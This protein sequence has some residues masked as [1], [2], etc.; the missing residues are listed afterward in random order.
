MIDNKTRLPTDTLSK[1]LSFGGLV[2]F[3]TYMSNFY[4]EYLQSDTW[5][6]RRQAKL[7]Q[8]KYKC[9]RCGERTRLQ[10]HHLNYKRLGNERSSDLIVLCTACH[11]VADSERRGDQEIRKKYSK[12]R[13][14]PAKILEP[15]KK[16][17]R[18][19]K[20]KKCDRKCHTYGIHNARKMCIEKLCEKCYYEKQGWI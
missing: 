14:V 8:A 16:I 2:L 13:E 1:Y 20:C 11:W 4:H 15:I 9:K 10:V 3:L 12:P 19:Y 6:E 7:Q 17:T 18:K 5:K